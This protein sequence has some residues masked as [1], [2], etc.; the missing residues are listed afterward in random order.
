MYGI[1]EVVYAAG[2]CRESNDGI[3]VAR[4]ELTKMHPDAVSIR[5]GVKDN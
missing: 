3:N 5:S 1:S 4:L 2:G